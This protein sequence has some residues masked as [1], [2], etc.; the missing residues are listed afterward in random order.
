MADPNFER[1]L[2]A[3]AGRGRPMGDHPDAA[4]LAAYVDR[5][6]SDAERAELEAHVANC[7]DC[8]GH[9]GL[10]ANVNVPDEPSAPMAW[11]APVW[12]TRLGWLV[13]IATAVLVV[14]IWVRQ[15]APSRAP[16]LTRSPTA[17]PI[18]QSA[19]NELKKSP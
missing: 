12:L 17:A 14:A 15:P 7:A 8:M 16:A 2:R 13:P 3:A 9:L 5:S 10:L 11:A 19:S 18:G 1:M 4:L 6:V